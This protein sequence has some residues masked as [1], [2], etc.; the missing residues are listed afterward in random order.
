MRETWTKFS[1]TH[2]CRVRGDDCI[3]HHMWVLTAKHIIYTFSSHT[4]LA[5]ET[6]TTY[7]G[8]MLCYWN[9]IPHN[10][11]GCLT[12]LYCIYHWFT[13]HGQKFEDTWTLQPCEIVEF[14]ILKHWVLKDKS[15]DLYI[16]LYSVLFWKNSM[17][18]HTM[19]V[20]NG[21]AWQITFN[22]AFTKY[23]NKCKVSEESLSSRSHQNVW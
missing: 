9:F 14:V 1:H 21:H 15:G 5:C 22:P 2:T 17:C 16:C 8:F 18:R 6:H 4:T 3:S 10:V 20:E 12:P 13:L 11:I 7:F 19:L 23:C